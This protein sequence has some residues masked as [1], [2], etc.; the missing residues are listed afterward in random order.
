V[1]FAVKHARAA[2]AAGHSLNAVLCQARIGAHAASR[3]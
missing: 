1:S 2:Q 3:W